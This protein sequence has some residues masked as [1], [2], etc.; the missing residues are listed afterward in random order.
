[1]V[2]L[3]NIKVCANIHKPKINLELLGCVDR[4]QTRIFFFTSVMFCE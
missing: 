2:K 4:G 3:R 1:M